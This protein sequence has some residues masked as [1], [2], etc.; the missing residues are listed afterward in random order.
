M[1]SPFS[2]CA[3]VCTGVLSLSALSTNALA[4][5]AIGRVRGVY[6]QE[7]R[8]VLAEYKG[9]RVDADLKR[10]VDVELE[11]AAGKRVLAEVPVGV[12]ARAGDRVGVEL[13][14][15]QHEGYGG[16]SGY[17]AGGEG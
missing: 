1:K 16:I 5:D 9:A 2:L 4:V 12:P 17:H 15:T 3:A 11:S 8:G 13:A 6:I 14:S 10:W 7:T